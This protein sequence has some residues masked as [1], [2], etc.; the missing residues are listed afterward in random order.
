[1]AESVMFN[2]PLTMN[3]PNK[4]VYDGIDLSKKKKNTGE[5]VRAS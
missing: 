1:M 4:K 3:S 5:K 2:L